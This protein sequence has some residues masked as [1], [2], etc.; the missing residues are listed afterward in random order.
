MIIAEQCLIKLT[1]LIILKKLFVLGL[2]A[3]LFV[4]CSD[5]DGEKLPVGSIPDI[6]QELTRAEQTDFA[7]SGNAF[8]GKMLETIAAVPLN[9]D[10]NI[11]ISPISMQYL[12]TMLANGAAPEALSELSSVMGMGGYTLEEINR[13]SHSLLEK[14]PVT[15]EYVTVALANSVWTDKTISVASAFSENLVAYY[16]ADVEQVDFF[17]NPQQAETAINSWASRNTNRMVNELSIDISS[18]TRAVLANATCFNGKW[19]YPFDKRFTVTGTFYNEDGTESQVP[20]MCKEASVLC[21]DDETLSAV[22][23]PYGK[24]YFSMMLVMPK[25]TVHPM[26]VL[27]GTDLWAL[28]GLMEKRSRVQFHVPRFKLECHW[29]DMLDVCRSMGIEWLFAADGLLYFS[30]PICNINQIVQDIVIEVTENGTSAAAVS[31][32]AS[33][34]LDGGST[35]NLTLNRPFVFAIRENTTGTVLFMGKIG[36]L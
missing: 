29:K 19:A 6:E 9:R 1:I 8:G 7:A 10:S 24:G 23:L 34:S 30:Q 12:L 15:D 32:G 14:L 25:S 2:A 22:E 20:M 3:A 21:Y 5:N 33:D 16:N 36:K 31:S 4:A 13:N 17:N 27:A 18:S 26:D 35:L 11:C 28:H